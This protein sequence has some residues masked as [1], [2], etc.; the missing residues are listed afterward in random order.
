[1]RCQRCGA[2]AAHVDHI[3]PVLLVGTDDL[4]TLQALCAARHVAKGTN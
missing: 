4:G 1:V 2:L 3:Q